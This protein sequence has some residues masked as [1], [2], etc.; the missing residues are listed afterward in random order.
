M[1]S[2]P[3]R[4]NDEHHTASAPVQSG[5]NLDENQRD[6]QTTGDDS[7]WTL[8]AEKPPGSP[9]P[10]HTHSQSMTPGEI[11][12]S[13]GESKVGFSVVSNVYSETTRLEL[14]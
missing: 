6:V 7:S 14:E 5:Q 12:A 11:I 1:A 3:I 10:I 13:G 4:R 8:P 9:P 2:S